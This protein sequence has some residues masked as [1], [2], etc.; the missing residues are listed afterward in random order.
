MEV[1]VKALQ[2][3]VEGVQGEQPVVPDR[4]LIRPGAGG[5]LAVQVWQ[6]GERE[7]DSQIVDTSLTTD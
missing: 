1:K 6:R 5:E 7:P 4:I 3:F 2:A